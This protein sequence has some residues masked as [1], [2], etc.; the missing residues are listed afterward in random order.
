[1]TKARHRVSEFQD[2]T[3]R[4]ALGHTM[5]LRWIAVGILIWGS[6]WIF[7][8]QHATPRQI[9]FLFLPILSLLALV[10]VAV[11]GCRHRLGPW[12]YWL[13]ALLLYIT[14]GSAFNPS[15]FSSWQHTNA[16]LLFVVLGMP[17]LFAL[18]QA[19][20]DL[21]ILC[22]TCIALS[23]LGLLDNT[24]TDL[25]AGIAGLVNSGPV[26]EGM[27]IA[28]V[29]DR[30]DSFYNRSQRAHE[31]WILFLT[32]IS[33]AALRPATQ[34]GW[35]VATIVLAMTG[36]AI[37]TGYSLAT[38]LTFI[39][40][41]GVF[42]AVLSA[43]RFMRG[44]SLLALLVFLLC[45]PFVAKTVWLWL[46]SNPEAF[47]GFS[48]ADRI[49]LRLARLEYWA[50][51][52]EQ[53]PWTG[54]GPGAYRELPR[55]PFDEAF[56]AREAYPTLV[57]LYDLGQRTGFPHN[58]S[59]HVWGELGVFGILIVTGFVARLFVDTFPVRPRDAGASARCALLV[60]VLFIFGVDR[61][62]YT[63][64]NIFQLVLTA[65]LAAGTMP[66]SA[67]SVPTLTLPGLS[68][69]RE[70]FLVLSLLLGG[71][72]VAAGSS[73]R[74]HFADSRYTPEHS[75]LDI[76]RG[77]VRLHGK[78][79]TLGGSPL[80]YI[81]GSSYAEQGKRG[82]TGVMTVSGWAYNP[83]ATSNT[84]R[85]LVFHGEKLLG[86]TR[87]GRASPHLQ[88]TSSQQNLDLLFAGFSLRIPVQSL[89]RN[90]Q[91]A[92]N[93]VFISPSGPAALASVT[94][95]ARQKLQA[96]RPN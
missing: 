66:V 36:L 42:F 76:E 22:G 88:R 59:L 10:A 37:A 77:V 1:M 72:L 32:W 96:I 64:Q 58:F 52:I 43:P 41:I 68:L 86:V 26:S 25:R 56:A 5:L 81:D 67:R 39:V 78:E 93:A 75:T 69:R 27:Q 70:C 19:S 38:R 29:T 47:N 62:A 30:S 94:T 6:V 28:I 60:S 79:L 63:G 18:G 11:A 80:G 44:L 13:G 8:F 16:I 90:P 9:E 46:M 65:G 89:G 33:L 48:E 74:V 7:L 35:V 24:G 3:Q 23:L 21:R 91:A 53:Q 12:A 2:E 82:N 95:S 54:L 87:T 51:I 61:V 92:I 31:V 34:R 17:V 84:I 4:A 20:I 40:S 55:M 49:V 85:V 57:Q 15:F 73:M 71:L 14:L 50:E 83:A 45:T